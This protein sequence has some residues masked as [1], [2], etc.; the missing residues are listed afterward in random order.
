MLAT[1]YN[2]CGGVIYLTREGSESVDTKKVIK[3]FEERFINMIKQKFKLLEP[4]FSFI[5][6]SLTF[7]MQASWAALI[8]RSTTKG[9]HDKIPADYHLDIYGKLLH[10]PYQELHKKKHVNVEETD[11]DPDHLDRTSQ[12]TLEDDSGADNMDGSP[13][14]TEE[15]L[16]GDNP[17]AG[18]TDNVDFSS[19][20]SLDFP[21][22]KKN[23]REN[24]DT[25]EKKAIRDIIANIHMLQPNEQMV[26][27]PDLDQLQCWFDSRTDMDYVIDRCKTDEHM[28]GFAIAIKS[29]GKMISGINPSQ[30]PPRRHI[31]DLLIVSKT[32]RMNFCVIVAD[33]DETNIKES[34]SYLM[35]TG[36]MLKYR[37]VQN[38]PQGVPEL[39]IQCILCSP[40]AKKQMSSLEEEVVKMQ[41]KLHDSYSNETVN[42][43]QL[44]EAFAN[45]IMWTETPLSRGS[46]DRFRIKFSEDQARIL[47]DTYGGGSDRV[48]YT[49]GPPGSGKSYIAAEMYKLQPAE[50]VYICTTKTFLK[51]LEHNGITGTLI[52]CGDDLIKEIEKEETFQNK[53]RIIIDDCHNFIHSKSAE[54]GMRKLFEMLK[55]N[56][57]MLLFIFADNDYQSFDK[58]NS[59]K[60][61]S[62]IYTLAKDVLGRLFISHQ[63]QEVFRNKKKVA[64]FIQFAVQDIE[65][66]KSLHKKIQCVNIKDGDGI[67]CI[68]LKYIEAYGSENGLVRYIHEMLQYYDQRDIAVLLDKSE[69]FEYRGL[70]KKCMPNQ[71]F[72]SAAGF[73]REGI[74]VDSVDS[75][76]G[77]DAS[78]CIFILPST[79]EDDNSLRSL[80][81]PRYRIFMA[82]RATDKAVFVVPKI[83]PALIKHMKFDR[84][85]VS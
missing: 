52:Q 42:F 40:K 41:K 32:G 39:F 44:Q 61:F 68:E 47:H 81:N 27:T 48:Y 4:P 80:A 29:G 55:E 25:K 16:P 63:L 23:W 57:K 59:Q 54:H 30:Q 71:N 12:P 74:V 60:M 83:D 72:Q 19:C 53:T 66:E 77:L 70:L 73:P 18:N 13:G 15:P 45:V 2:T 1:L 82:S 75:F 31:C 84:F 62:C 76:L 26:F 20:K 22:N 14:L 65:K 36:R 49:R 7:D 8:L 5:E 34:I 17:S 35:I 67:Q 46:S 38:W 6:I 58:E 28:S 21:K 24:L 79:S 56:E 85:P 50:S 78:L 51:Y 10:S 33:K 64:S 43:E 11:A 3:V 69:Q 9:N 37:L